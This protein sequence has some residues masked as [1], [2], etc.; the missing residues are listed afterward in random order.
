A[1]GVGVGVGVGVKS[2]VDF[3]DDVVESY[4][5]IFKVNPPLRTKSDVAA[6]RAG[7]ADGTINI[8]ATDHAP[9]PSEDKIA[10]GLQLHL[11]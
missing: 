11:E 7:L 5:P 6:V 3:T 9:H 8:V 1:I 2:G 4:D 10:N